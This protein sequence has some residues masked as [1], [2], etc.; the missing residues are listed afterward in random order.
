VR[1]ELEPRMARITSR[2]EPVRPIGV[3]RAIRGYKG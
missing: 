1:A 2:A 3:I